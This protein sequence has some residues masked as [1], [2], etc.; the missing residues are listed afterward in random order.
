MLSNIFI[1]RPR[2]AIVLSLLIGVVGVLAILRIPVAQYPA[3]AP[4][5]VIVSTSYDGAGAETVEE[6][7]AQPIEDAV[8]GVDG[9]KYMQSVSSA[10]G[11]Y[12][13]TVSFETG[14]DP[15]QAAVAVQNRVS[16]ALAR[17]PG[18]VRQTGVS[19]QKAA[20]DLLLLFAI[21]SPDDSRDTLFISNYATL[22]LI[23]VLTRVPGVG[24][25]TLYGRRDYAMR[26]W[27]DPARMTRLGV[28]VE[29]VAA[30]IR[31][32]NARAT[33][34]AIGTAPTPKGQEIELVV[35]GGQGPTTAEEFGDIVLRS[36]LGQGEV[37][38]SDVARVEL[39]AAS[40]T[41]AVEFEDH[42][43]VA[44][45]I[46]LAPGANAVSVASAV[47]ERVEAAKASMPTGL[48]VTT[49]INSADFV[50]QMVG[51][52]LE[53]LGIAFALVAAVVLVFIGRLRAALIPL[54]AAPVSI[55]G[56]LAVLYALGF[57]AN[58][59]TLL[60]L[61][62]AIGIVVDDAIVVA[63]NVER[64]M[65]EN[66]DIAPAEAASRAM[67][68][69]TP[70]IV[71]ITL[72]LLA[73]F[74]PVSFIPGSSGVLFQQFA[75]AISGAVVI[76]ALN[77]LTL[78]PALA[79]LLLRPG[80]PVLLLRG[81]TGL[82]GLA[83]RGYTAV[84]RL[85]L[86][87]SVLALVAVVALGFGAERL[88]ETTPSGFVP[89]EDKG[90][91][92]VIMDLPAGA[93]LERTERV[94]R[95][96]E[97]TIEADPA[98]ESVATVLGIDFLGGGSASNAGVFFVKLK[99]YGA[100]REARL[101]SFA[102]AERLR[103]ALAPI[104]EAVLIA[105]NPPAI[106]GLGRV[107][108][109]DYVL[110]ARAGQSEADLAAVALGLT[111]AASARP[112]IARAYTGASSQT[113]RIRL[114]ID[115][116]Q[117]LRLG[118]G[119]TSIFTALQGL[120]G[121]LY[122]DDFNLYGRSWTIRLQAEGAA[123]RT[124]EDV[125]AV[126]VRAEDGTLVPLS[127]FA[128]TSIELGPRFIARY[129]A[130]RALI[131]TVLPAPAAGSG[132]A[133][134][135]MEAVSS[136]TLPAGYGFEWTGQALQEIEASGRTEIVIALAVLFVYLFLVALYESWAVPVAV[137]LSV[138]VAVLGALLAI[139][140]FG[141]SVDV[142]AQIGVIVLI[143]LAAKNAILI[144]SFALARRAAGLSAR[145]AAAEGARLRFRPVMMTSVAFIAGLIPLAVA[146]GPG[147]G[148]MRAV[149]T[150]VLGGMLAA[151]LVGIFLIPMLFFAVEW[152]RERFGPRSAIRRAGAG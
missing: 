58:A 118:V 74:V 1:Q 92:F 10:D 81:F 121:G 144:V 147:A 63:E 129:D 15:E 84:T 94:A 87:V 116:D 26:I 65:E 132:G 21:W 79:A 13:L 57:S 77:A 7:I 108:G 53:T 22:D 141:L 151:T 76:S 6:A 8:N 124:P 100:R 61:V 17:L 34:G 83:G 78:S 50:R 149:G 105:A 73:V 126:P 142:Y 117:A 56:G 70:S 143:A 101:S 134:A 114:D 29:E 82:V 98:V 32:Q 131:V 86:R 130:E 123:R 104:P 36:T 44:V 113:P 99:P 152:L 93:A 40:L 47:T 2:L 125:L 18:E 28:S 89:A 133:I 110:Q 72:V 24:E 46:A 148:A 4:P 30:A 91:L 12:R 139:R 51:T 69:I 14:K 38:L 35:S 33:A 19:V 150:P 3:I 54:V 96:A 49:V 80:K 119:M 127:T 55:I 60:A 39:G 97:A 120:L 135:A 136:A 37:R 67:H 140:Q 106:S 90:S 43:G 66:P 25:V 146:E 128:R 71:A 41:N 137:L 27:L 45:G 103:R 20:G 138:P 59:I 85:L 111:Q 112:E 75:A 52:V 23:D 68:E 95:K 11:S 31:S 107:G 109:L 16:S 122:V 64:V 5:T 88:F 48:S 42:P 9:L 62:L 115:R 102:T 145:D